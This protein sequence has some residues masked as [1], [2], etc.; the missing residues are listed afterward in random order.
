MNIPAYLLNYIK[1][2]NKGGGGITPTGEINITENGTYDVTNYA[3]ANVNIPSYYITDC[4]YLCSDNHRVDSD[5]L[6][7]IPY[8]VKP[9]SVS[10]M[11][12]LSSNLVNAP[13]FDTSNTTTFSA[14]FY[15]CSNLETVPLYDTSKGTD[16]LNMFSNCLKLTSVPQFDFT[17]AI[18]LGYLFQNC[19]TLAN[20]PVFDWSSPN[21]NTGVN[22]LSK[23]FEGCSSLTNDS[24]N[25]ILATFDSI[26]VTLP[27]GRLKL[28]AYGISS[29]QADICVTLSNWQG[30]VDKGW[31]TGY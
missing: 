27:S 18:Y 29:S 4:Q 1:N 3:T 28:S 6:S 15:N 16:F 11:F 21:L 9:T 30:L 5:S 26:S 13:L 12:R 14:M 2:I 17:N 8:I 23:I 10:Q 20:V 25:N 22:G 24:L 7:I 19:T 31:T